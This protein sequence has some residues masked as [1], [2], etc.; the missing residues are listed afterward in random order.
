MED[1][2]LPVKVTVPMAFVIVAL[3]VVRFRS[4]ESVGVP[5]PVSVPVTVRL[6]E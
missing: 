3:E 2:E 5:V 6:P 1:A 4:T